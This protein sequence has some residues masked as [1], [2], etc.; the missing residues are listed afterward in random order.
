MT[1][2]D[3]FPIVGIGASAGG[4]EALEGFFRAVPPESGMA[5]V[6][7]THLGSGHVSILPEIIGRHYVHAGRGRCATATRS[8]PTTSTCCRP[9]RSRRS[10][11]A[12]CACA[13]RP[14]SSAS[15]TRSTSSSQPR[16]GPGRARDRHHP[17]RRRQRRHARHQGDQGARRADPGPGRRRLAGRATRACPTA[18]SPPAWSTSS[19]PVEEIPAKLVDYAR[20]CACHRRPAPRADR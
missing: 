16:R 19:L 11:R 7:V 4:V 18:P 15:A 8:R 20:A 6:V 10:R 12:P 13:P 5:Y 9:M 3:R 17:L 2:N 14:R 1:A